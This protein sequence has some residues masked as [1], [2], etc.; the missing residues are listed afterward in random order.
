MHSFLL[1]RQGEQEYTWLVS[2]SL[3]LHTQ[4][5]L[6]CL[7]TH[8]NKC[9]VPLNTCVWI[10]EAICYLA[11]DAKHTSLY[12]TVFYLPSGAL[13]A[14]S[15]S[16]IGVYGSMKL[17]ATWLVMADSILPWSNDSFSA[18]FL[19]TAWAWGESPWKSEKKKKKEK[20]REREREREIARNFF[21][22]HFLL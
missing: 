20:K 7:F 2:N 1:T 12:N 5:S 6:T 13:A 15:S 19:A 17:S 22:T 3:N 9:Q 10:H 18:S 16:L 21:L 11:S 4:H 14:I 8:H